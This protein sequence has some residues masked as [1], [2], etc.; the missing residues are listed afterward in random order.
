MTPKA[1]QYRPT[2]CVEN[3]M[4]THEQAVSTQRHIAAN[5]ATKP[6]IPVYSTLLN[7]LWPQLVSTPAHLCR[8]GGRLD[9]CRIDYVRIGLLRCIVHEAV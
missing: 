7:G 8:V 9:D 5:V 4:T 1:Q 3:D 2:V 6:V